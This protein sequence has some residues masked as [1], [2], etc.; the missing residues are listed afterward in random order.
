[1]LVNRHRAGP[2]SFAQKKRPQ[3]GE[4]AEADKFMPVL[5]GMILRY[6][7]AIRQRH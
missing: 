4:K 6:R 5:I 2:P 3:L 7:F 1:M